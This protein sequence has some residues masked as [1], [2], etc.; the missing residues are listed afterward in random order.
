ME[1]CNTFSLE[2]LYN[3]LDA[4]LVLYFGAQADFE[5]SLK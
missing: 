3:Q 1:F 5:E 2:V 4:R